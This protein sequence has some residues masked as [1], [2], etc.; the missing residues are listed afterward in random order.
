M[1]RK[2]RE[3]LQTAELVDRQAKEMLELFKQ[4]RVVR[5]SLSTVRI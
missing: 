1:Q 3:R 5:G 4:A 2:E